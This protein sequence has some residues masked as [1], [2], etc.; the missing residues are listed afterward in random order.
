MT[1]TGSRIG[2]TPNSCSSSVPPEQVR[3]SQSQPRTRFYTTAPRDR[4]GAIVIPTEEG[5]DLVEGPLIDAFLG[6]TARDELFEAWTRALGRYQATR[7]RLKIQLA[8][9]GRISRSALASDISAR[10]RSKP[11]CRLSQN[12]AVVPVK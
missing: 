1:D 11:I 3:W 2:S 10:R 4:I 6:G 12:C 9:S 8:F 5:G 7:G